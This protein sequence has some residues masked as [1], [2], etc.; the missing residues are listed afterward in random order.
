MAKPEETAAE[1]TPMKSRETVKY[2]EQV[3]GLA[4]NMF[5]VNGHSDRAVFTM[6]HLTAQRS[7][8]NLTPSDGQTIN[9]I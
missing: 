7:T 3:Q 2:C 4:T 5:K 9:I 8:E 1:F 6:Y